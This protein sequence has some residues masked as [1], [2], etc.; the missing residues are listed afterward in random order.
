MLA[1]SVLC[2]AVLVLIVLARIGTTT[3]NQALSDRL[4]SVV[5][6]GFFGVLVFVMAMATTSV[7]PR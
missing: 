6:W 1:V 7:E 5:F 2:T 3:R 4:S